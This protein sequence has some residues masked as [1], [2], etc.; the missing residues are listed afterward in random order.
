[1]GNPLGYTAYAGQCARGRPCPVSSPFLSE[2]LYFTYKPHIKLD[3]DEVV[4]IQE[5]TYCDYAQ[6]N[7]VQLSAPVSILY[8]HR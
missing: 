5:F 3:S 6:S 8:N 1:M 2:K 4:F 7:T